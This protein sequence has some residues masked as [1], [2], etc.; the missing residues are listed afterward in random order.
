[1]KEAARILDKVNDETVNVLTY[2]TR[3]SRRKCILYSVAV[4]KDALTRE[5]MCHLRRIQV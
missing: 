2:D 1:M 4:V 3:G 5:V